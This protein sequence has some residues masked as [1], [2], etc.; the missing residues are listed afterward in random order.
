MDSV[1]EAPSSVTFQYTFYFRENNIKIVS[2]T[3][4]SHYEASF[5]VQAINE[6]WGPFRFRLGFL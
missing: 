4:I 1:P 6:N 2:L 5:A 3:G